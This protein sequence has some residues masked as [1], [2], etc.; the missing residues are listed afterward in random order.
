MADQT[1]TTRDYEWYEGLAGA[2]VLGTLSPEERADFER[3]LAISPQLRAEVASLSPGANALALAAEERT[4][5]PDLR[6]RLAA[7][8]SAEPNFVPK[9][10]S[11]TPPAPIS[12]PDVKAA[13]GWV[14]NPLYAKIAAALA[15]V[16]IGS[17]LAWNFSLR[18]D[19]SGGEP[20]VIAQLGAFDPNAD[21]GATGEVLYQPSQ[22]ILQLKM[23]DLP[24][25][26]DNEVYQLWFITDDGSAPVPSVVFR[27][28]DSGAA[29]IAV[30]ADPSTF[31]ILAITREPGPVGGGSP[32]TSPFLAASV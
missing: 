18:N 2:Y 6:N 19:Q 24:G 9:T 28:D 5:S 27:P 21:T 30:A 10:A 29:T 13:R 4:P 1:G 26:P 14:V 22:Q 25:L 23:S 8:I 15:V 17:L 32:T 11:T 7:A 12:L 3:V 16:L 20:E 31:D